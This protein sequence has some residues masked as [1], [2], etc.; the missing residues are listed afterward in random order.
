MQKGKFI[1][2]EGLDGSGKGTQIKLL[3][4]RLKDAGIKIYPTFEPTNGN[5]GVLIREALSGKFKVTQNTIGLMFSADRTEHNTEIQKALDDGYCVICDRYYYST[6]A[7]QGRGSEEQFLWTC[8]L[9]LNNS[10][11]R[12]PDLCVFLDV[13]PDI[14]MDRIDTN[15]DKKEIYEKADILREVRSEYQK[16][17]D[18]MKN[19]GRNENITVIPSD[20]EKNEISDKL[21][22]AVYK[23]IVDKA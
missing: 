14:C 18:Y 6:I 9:N 19:I 7:Y 5:I 23:T 8:A 12:K 2:I 15:R 17:F 4:Q 20:G 22:D 21:F 16:L 11:I 10:G 1:V 3:C 13:N